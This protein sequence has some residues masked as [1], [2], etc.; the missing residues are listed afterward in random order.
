MVEDVDADVIALLPELFAA[1]LAKGRDDDYLVRGRGRHC[2]FSN[3]SESGRA[4]GKGR[5]YTRYGTVEFV[6]RS[7]WVFG[8]GVEPA[9]DAAVRVVV[10][11]DGVGGYG[12]TDDVAEDAAQADR[13]F[14]RLPTAPV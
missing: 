3:C 9:L 1:W 4:G 8:P 10:V 5:G 6:R 7:T 11:V 2:Q 14:R 12:A 13:P